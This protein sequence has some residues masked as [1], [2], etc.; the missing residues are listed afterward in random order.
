MSEELNKVEFQRLQQRVSKLENA[1]ARLD[2]SLLSMD[3]NQVVI[4]GDVYQEVF[5]VFYHPD[6]HSFTPKVDLVDLN[7]A[8]LEE[9]AEWDNSDFRK[10][11]YAALVGVSEKMGK[12]ID[13][14]FLVGA[15]Q[16]RK[17]G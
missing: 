6:K 3:N 5:G 2:S 11:V 4:K 9:S 12:P 17:S 1:F 15:Y 16:G 10:A 8:I 13:V 14:S 7:Q